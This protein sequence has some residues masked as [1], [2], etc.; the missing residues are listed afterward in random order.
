MKI[1]LIDDDEQVAKLVTATLTAQR[2]TVDVAVDGLDG[3]DLINSSPYDLILLDVMLPKLDGISFCRRLRAKKKQTPVI[4]LTARDTSIDKMTGLDAGADDYLV[5]PLDLQELTARIRALLRRGGSDQSPILTWGNLQLDPATLEVKFGEQPLN[6][7][8]KEFAI[9][10]LLLRN[11]QRVFSRSAI[12]D[13]LWSFDEAPGEETIKAHIKAIRQQ[14][15][16]VGAEDLIETLYGQGYRLNPEY[17][18][19]KLSKTATQESKQTQM[20]ATRS[21]VA[22]IWQQTKGVSFD[23]VAVL[24]QALQALEVGCLDEDL[25]Q[26][27]EQSAHKLLGSLGTFGFV[28][29]AQ[30]AKQLE[31]LFGSISSLEQTP[32]HKIR[33]LVVTLRQQLEENDQLPESN[34]ETSQTTD[35][36]LEIQ[37]AEIPTRSD[38]PLLLIV[39]DD[40][41]LTKQL[42]SAAN[43]WK[44]RTSIAPDL[45]TARKEIR[46]NRPDVVLLDLALE[47]GENG[48]ALLE[49]MAAYRSQIPVLVFT[50]QDRFID[51]VTVAR[52]GGHMFLQKPT[53]VAEVMKAVSQV[54]QQAHKG[55]AKILTVD[56]DPQVR[57]VLKAL[58]EPWGLQVTSLEDPTQ[59]WEVLKTSQ[60]D[61]VMLDVQM[62]EIDG[63]ELCQAIRSDPQWSW[64]PVLFL[65]ARTDTEI[66]YRVFEVGGDDYISKP[67]VAA[68]LINR[69]FNRLERTRLLRSQVEIDPITG[70]TNRQQGTQNLE[71]LLEL[72]KHTNQPVCV[73]VLDIDNLEQINTLHGYAAGEKALRQVGQLLKQKLRQE[74][75]V[76][77]WGGA[78]FVVGMYGMTQTDGVEWLAE[79]LESLRSL[80]ILAPSG[81]D[82]R[83]SFSAGVVQYPVDG[84]DV[85]MLYR[86]ADTVLYRAREIGGDRVLPFGWQPA[87]NEPFDSVNVVLIHPDTELASQIFQALQTRGYHTQWFK[88]VTEAVAPLTGTPSQLRPSAIILG[89]LAEA[90]TLSTL[91]QLGSKTLKQIALLLLS[92]DSRQAEAALQMGASDYVLTPCSIPIVMQSLRNTLGA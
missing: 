21:A 71:K 35:N 37:S 40:Q 52:L 90:E 12:L 13:Q 15:R 84:I 18:T 65:T 77:R 58:L 76:I 72:A 5:K 41:H 68:E 56:D 51:R 64:L 32:V 50:E 3:W 44:F 38:L 4:L 54:L 49:E 60:P 91:K 63:I 36:G 89:G 29:S 86:T 67:I 28:E 39:D 85:Q 48:L 26:K 82:F 22:K 81:E 87:T 16:L 6:L 74:D 14:L 83:T 31:K 1:L 42:A 30:I 46:Q 24:E 17:A 73:A 9:L 7:R 57:L 23:R 66:M 20:Q 53:N 2:Y 47:A 34:P 62:P 59:F 70:V 10:E 25:C 43:Q 92:P 61:L 80:S 8:R 88:S 78:E 11:K 33:Q 55:T 19:T 27:A 75:V 45:A 69:I 79:I